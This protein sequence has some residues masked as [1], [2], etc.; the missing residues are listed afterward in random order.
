MNTLVEL[1]SKVEVNHAITVK[2]KNLMTVV[3]LILTK[4]SCLRLK[5]LQMKAVGKFKNLLFKRRPELLKRQLGDE[6]R[7]VQPLQEESKQTEANHEASD[8]PPDFGGQGHALQK[9]RSV[10]L[11]DR[12][13]VDG[14]LSAEGIHHDINASIPDIR[15]IS[16]RMDT[17]ITTKPAGARSADS[18]DGSARR[19]EAH[20]S[21]IQTNSTR[22]RGVRNR[23]HSQG[24]D[25]KGQAHDPMD[26]EVLWLGIGSGEADL[27]QPSIE[28]VAESPSAAEFGIYDK[29]YHDEVQRIREAQG[30]E[31]TVYLTR[32]VDS[33]REYRTDQHMIQEPKQDEVAGR[34]HA[35]WKGV[36]D[37]ARAADKEEP[38][39][40]TEKESLGQNLANIAARI[41]EDAKAVGENVKTVGDHALGKSQ[42]LDDDGGS[43]VADVWSK[44]V[45]GVGGEARAQ[46]PSEG[47]EQRL[48]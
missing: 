44:V 45:D 35:G 19:R 46:A 24:T 29:A 34:A 23:P 33:K 13:A 2:F 30:H 7:I 12:R 17:S 1:P 47:V 3:S 14:A 40:D 22:S 20:E 39:P 15:T 10:D 8:S 9:S 21:D 48:Q 4:S 26:H 16:D 11:D 27:L 36:L 41:R 43:A 25:G 42:Q 31:A 6:V 37:A 32:R 5:C 28:I 38:K 18:P